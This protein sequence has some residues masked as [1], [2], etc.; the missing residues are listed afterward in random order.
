M[1]IVNADKAPGI[2]RGGTLVTVRPEVELEVTAGDIPD[3]ITADLSGREIGDV[4]HIEDVALPAGAKPTIQRNFVIANITAPSGLR[5]SE[6]EAAEDE[7][8]EV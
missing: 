3:H 7:T 2:K 8:E 4:V 1:E 6:D 5:S